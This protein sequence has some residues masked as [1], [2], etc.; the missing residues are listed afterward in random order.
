MP[1]RALYLLY[2]RLKDDPAY[3]V[4]PPGRSYQRV[5]FTVVIERDGS[6]VAIQDAR[7]PG[8]FN[9]EPRRVLVLGQT[10]PSGSGLNP[11]FL[12]DAP[13]Y[14]LGWDAH[15]DRA[16]R[17]W[18]TFE[19]FRDRHLNVEGEVGVPEFSAVCRFLEKWNP[20]KASEFKGILEEVSTGFGVF[21]IRGESAF[22]HEHPA[23]KE[24]WNLRTKNDPERMKQWWEDPTSFENTEAKIG[25]CL[26]TGN[27]SK[28]ARL[29]S[30]IKGVKGAQTSGATIA[31]FNK[32]AYWS[33][34]FEQ[35]YNAPVSL[36]AAFAYVNALNALL[37][38]PRRD[39]HRIVVG[40]TT[41]VFWTD[42][43][44]NAEDV[45]A[46]FLGGGSKA[47]EEAQDET[48]R[49]KLQAFLEA[50]KKG[51]EVYGEIDQAPHLTGYYILGLAAP[52]PA[53]ITIRFFH[54]G[55]I[56]ELLEN[57]RGHFAD[58]HVEQQYK[59]HAKCPDPELPPAWALLAE[60]H[61]R[62]GDP[63]PLLPPAFIES[64]LTG[65][66]YPDGLF[67]A[68]MR[69]ISADRKVNYLRACLIKG[70]LVRNLERFEKEE[71]VSLEKSRTEPAYRL[72]RL[73]AALEKTQ[74]EALGS[75][76]NATIR[77]RFYSSASATPAAVF[78]RLLRTYQH[79]LAKLNPGA[80]VNR[81]KLVQE[82]LDPIKSFPAHLDL[83]D[84]GLFALGYYH[85]R[86][87]FFRSPSEE[88]EEMN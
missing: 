85:Q 72:G 2:E 67:S 64:I 4:P 14:L 86:N 52:T 22:V 80:K 54:R 77:D 36:K 44:S 29:H 15:T 3:Q 51:R 48:I 65:S 43:P 76:V 19:A 7:L 57:L 30:K 63:S 31:G 37:N 28:I 66:R 6:L 12:W 32:D 82:I 13:G 20:E 8:R 68:V 24:W 45:F 70:Y 11:C 61:P 53:R 88:P 49:R 75:K 60:T 17:S 40:G 74:E 84:Q 87:E 69:R 79:H 33:Y 55:T 18:K 83:A 59:K 62:G 39:K 42:R 27:V 50:L 34:G 47:L 71:V 10:K 9:P 58:L 73:F 16:A 26:V 21:Q 35:S 23:I 46:A 78:P 5:T 56:T 41:M 25:Q 1:L 38:G 81:E